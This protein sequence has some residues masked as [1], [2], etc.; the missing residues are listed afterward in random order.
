MWC[1]QVFLRV[2]SADLTAIFRLV[3]GIYEKNGIKLVSRTYLNFNTNH[4]VF[5][6]LLF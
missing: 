1:I 3:Y 5:V 2:F 4:S 6:L